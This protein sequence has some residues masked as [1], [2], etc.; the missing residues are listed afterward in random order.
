MS[1]LNPFSYFRRQPV[2]PVNQ[3]NNPYYD[4]IQTPYGTNPNTYANTPG[5]YSNNYNNSYATPNANVGQPPN[6]LNTGTANQN[7]YNNYNNTTVVNEAQPDYAYQ[8]G[9]K[10]VGGYSNPTPYRQEVVEVPITE[11]NN[12][13]YNY[14]GPFKRPWSTYTPTISI[15]GILFFGACVIA[16]I[17]MWAVEANKSCVGLDQCENYLILDIGVGM[18]LLGGIMFC[19]FAGYYTAAYRLRLFD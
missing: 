10:V 7:A 12:I 13:Q 16:G 8:G 6:S 18:T 19:G 5:A 14:Y 15:L 9:Q 17:P 4:N 11:A 1:Y 2:E 3:A